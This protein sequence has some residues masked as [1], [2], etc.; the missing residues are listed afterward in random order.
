[1]TVYFANLFLSVQ[2]LSN[3]VLKVVE[4]EQKMK[5]KKE[6]IEGRKKDK[7][8]CSEYFLQF[9]SLNGFTDIIQCTQ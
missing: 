7:E 6:R 4:E 1:M 5:R 2:Q 3:Y 9:R 8:I